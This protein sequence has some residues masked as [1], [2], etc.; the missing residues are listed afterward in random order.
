MQEPVLQRFE[1]GTFSRLSGD[2]SRSDFGK[3]VCR[4][5]AV[6]FMQA[7]GKA[8]H[9]RERRRRRGWKFQG[10]LR[11]RVLRSGFGLGL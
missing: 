10:R 5:V 6:W 8:T 9:E 2:D 7:L 4:F 1:A 3:P 11:I